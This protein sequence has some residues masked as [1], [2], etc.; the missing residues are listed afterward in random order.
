LLGQQILLEQPIEAQL[1]MEVE[2]GEKQ[3][4]LTIQ[5]RELVERDIVRSDLQ[6]GVLVIVP[7]H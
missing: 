6:I 3:L 7:L 4:V 1:I 5:I 2:E